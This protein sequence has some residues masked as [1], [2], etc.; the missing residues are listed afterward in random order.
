M[1]TTIPATEPIDDLS[2]YIIAGRV[3]ATPTVDEPAN[4]TASRSPAQGVADG[5]EAEHIGFRRIFLSERWNLK[6][7]STILAG[8]AALTTRLEVGAGLITPASRHPLHTAAFGAT[9]HACFGPRLVLGFGRGDPDHLESQGLSAF[10]L[11]ETE[12]YVDIV[13]RLWDGET[14]SYTGSIGRYPALQLGDRYDGPRPQLWFGTFALPRAVVTAA[15]SFD[16]V[17]LPPNI[18]PR[19]TGEAVQRLRKACERVDR[20]PGTLRIA[21]CVITAPELGD[22]ETIQLAHG[23]LVTYLT[24]PTYGDALIEL[25]GWDPAS[26]RAVCEHAQVRELAKLADSTFFRRQLTGPAALIPSEWITETCA[27]GSVDECLAQLQRFRDAGAD[28]IVTYGSTPGQ[29]AELARRW[30]ARTVT[31]GTPARATFA[32]EE[33]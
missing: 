20:D 12:T 16:G 3:E 22:A 9:M 19:A 33:K 24:I 11:S 6:E 15:R 5:V 1:S 31:G 8:I 28:E 21:Q 2:A 14:V 17:L 29:N 32:A 25:N 26:R 27:I 7:A 10:T 13:R 18:T 23:R 4:Q 30:A